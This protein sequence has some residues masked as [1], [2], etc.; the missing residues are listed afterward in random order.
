MTTHRR[1]NKFFPLQIFIIKILNFQENWNNNTRNILLF[2]FFLMFIHFWERERDR[3]RERHRIQSRLQA[4]SR[5]HRPWHGAWTHELWDHDLS[6]S[7]TLNRLSHSG[8]LQETVLKHLPRPDIYFILQCCFAYIWVYVC[9]CVCMCVLIVLFSCR[10]YGA[11]LSK[12]FR[13]L[14][15]STLLFSVAHSQWLT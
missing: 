5:E 11:L 8:A 13:E 4:L 14:S 15:Q 10:Y 7:Q 6:Q 3:E 12:Y 1:K 9:M 2:F